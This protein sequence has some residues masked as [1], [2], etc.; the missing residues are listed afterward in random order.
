MFMKHKAAERWGSWWHQSRHL[1]LGSFLGRTFRSPVPEL[2]FEADCKC[3]L[4]CLSLGTE[5]LQKLQRE[6]C[7][8]PRDELKNGERTGALWFLLWG[9]G[10]V[11]QPL[12][13]VFMALAYPWSYYHD[14]RCEL[15]C[16]CSQETWVFHQAAVSL[17]WVISLQVIPS[18][19][20]RYPSMEPMPGHHIA[21]CCNR[22]PSVQSALSP[23]STPRST[24][25][26]NHLPHTLASDKKTHES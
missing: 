3:V 14:Q 12:A 10:T 1:W 7:L 20:L 22:I 9:S 21:G 19:T 11:R 5:E 23:R 16:L 24:T 15:S 2:A 4:Q 17:D 18:T 6:K 26:Q 13:L 8:C 25:S